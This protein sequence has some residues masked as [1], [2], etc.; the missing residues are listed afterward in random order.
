S[1]RGQAYELQVCRE[2]RRVLSRS[3]MSSRLPP[4]R[5]RREDIMPLARHFAAR[6]AR[7]GIEPVSFSRDASL[8]LV[9]YDWPGNIRE[10]ENAVKIGRASGRERG[11]SPW[12]AVREGT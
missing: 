2:F 11:R 4:L 7:A 12:V 10:L 8:A 3:L 9:A 5:G 1:R 6:T